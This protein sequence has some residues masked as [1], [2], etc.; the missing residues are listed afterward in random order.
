MQLFQI[1]S[2]TKTCHSYNIIVKSRNMFNRNLAVRLPQSDDKSKQTAKYFPFL[3][4]T[5]LME[6]KWVVFAVG[7]NM[8][9][10]VVF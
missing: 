7:F 9:F 3:S 8:M 5:P 2:A 6:V 10:L 1:F 4:A